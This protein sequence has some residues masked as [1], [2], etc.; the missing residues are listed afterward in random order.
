MTAPLYPPDR[1]ITAILQPE[2]ADIPRVY[3]TARMRPQWEPRRGNF[4]LRT[5]ILRARLAAP[6]GLSSGRPS[7][8]RSSLHRN[9]GRFGEQPR[10]FRAEH[11]AAEPDGGVDLGLPERPVGIPSVA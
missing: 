6:R 8:G 5:A 3:N 10:I 11:R 4:A 2:G 9:F 1:A 7:F